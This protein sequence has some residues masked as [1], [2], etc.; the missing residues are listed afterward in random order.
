MLAPL[1]AASIPLTIGLAVLTGGVAGGIVTGI[2]GPIVTGRE[3]RKETFRAWQTKLGEDFLTKIAQVR[4]E[5]LTRSGQ[6]GAPAPKG[7]PIGEL[8]LLAQRIHL[9]FRA[10]VKTPHAATRVV[11]A[12]TNGDVAM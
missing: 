9:V 2:L 11:E 6:T 1:V 4:S 8:D 3:A 5:L 7:D 12:A 10:G